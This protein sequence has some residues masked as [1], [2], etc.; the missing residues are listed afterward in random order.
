[1]YYNKR[2]IMVHLLILFLMILCGIVMISID[3]S[4]NVFISIMIAF[5]GLQQL[6]R[7]YNFK[8]SSKKYNL[9][10]SLIF[11]MILFILSILFIFLK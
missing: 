6:V 9:L 4:Y 7:V 11:S 1:M 10:I 5:M 2:I 8:K 3:I